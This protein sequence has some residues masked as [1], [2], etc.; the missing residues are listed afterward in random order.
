MAV[1]T[2]DGD[3]PL[4]TD[5]MSAGGVMESERTWRPTWR[6]DRAMATQDG[7]RESEIRETKWAMADKIANSAKTRTREQI[8]VIFIISR[9][10]N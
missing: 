9:S 4:K 7:D 6:N 2:Q 3:L 10:N 5:K 1:C 8:S